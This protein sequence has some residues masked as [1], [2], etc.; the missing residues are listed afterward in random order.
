MRSERSKQ[1]IVDAMMSLIGEGNL[2]PTAQ[3]VSEHAG[4]GIRSVFRHFSDMES[5]FASADKRMRAEDQ[6]LFMGGNR[7]GS[8]E[9]RIGRAVER[10][11]AGYEFR[12]NIVLSTQAQL[13]RFEVLRKNYARAQRALRKDWESWIP[14]LKDL[15]RNQ[16]EAVDAVGSFEMWHRLREHQGLSK[17]NTI[18]LLKQMLIAL[19]EQD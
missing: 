12:Q 17:K 15:A 16:R 5:L 2:A 7:Q 4:V 6:A 19:I 18:A 13:W 8:L 11:A 3:Q 14:E 1:A 9:E 10:H